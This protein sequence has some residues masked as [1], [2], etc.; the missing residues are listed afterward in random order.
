MHWLDGIERVNSWRIGWPDS[1]RGIVGSFDRAEAA[2]A[3][4]RVLRGMFRRTVIRVDDV[5][6]RA[7]AGAI[8]AGLIVRARQRKQRIEQARFL[9][10]EKNGI[11]AKLRAE[12]ARAEFVVGLARIV[13]RAT[14]SPTSPFGPAA[15]FEHA[16]DV[17]GLRNLPALERRDFRQA[18]PLSASLPAMGGGIVRTVC[19]AP[20]RA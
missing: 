3:E 20:S 4:W 18:C 7:A 13:G 19:G 6:R 2:I 9:Q 12:S 14:G 5:A 10:A 15:A 16:Q 11:G 17:A 8:I 1:S